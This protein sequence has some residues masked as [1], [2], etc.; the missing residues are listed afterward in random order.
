[1]ACYSIEVTCPPAPVSL[2]SIQNSTEALYGSVVL[3][4]CQTGFWF[5]NKHT[6][7]DT[8]MCLEN[9][10]WSNTIEDCTGS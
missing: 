9:N 10:T 7:E 1:M 8:S 6:L 4:K 5:K 3:Y 2:H